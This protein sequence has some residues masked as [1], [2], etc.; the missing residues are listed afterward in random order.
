VEEKSVITFYR[1]QTTD[2]EKLS[3]EDAAK[4][5]DKNY[6]KKA[7]CM[8]VFHFRDEPL[9]LA[10][11]IENIILGTPPLKND[12]ENLTYSGANYMFVAPVVGEPIWGRALVE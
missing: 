10:K 4:F 6:G 5:V 1:L 3:Y 9:Y 8:Q 2:A 7:I 11:F 12:I